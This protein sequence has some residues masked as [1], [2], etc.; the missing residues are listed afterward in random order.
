MDRRVEESGALHAN[1][2]HAEANAIARRDPSLAHGGQGIGNWRTD[3][4][5]TSDGGAHTKEV[6][7]GELVV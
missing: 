7:A 3:K 2:D 1:A 4:R 5:G 6:T